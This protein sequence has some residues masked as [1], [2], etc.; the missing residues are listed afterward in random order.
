MGPCKN[1]EKL[2]SGNYHLYEGTE[3]RKKASWQNLAGA[4]GGVGESIL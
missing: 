2:A 4:Y 1:V 3:L